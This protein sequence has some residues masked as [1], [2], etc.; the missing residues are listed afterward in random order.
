MKSIDP[1]SFGKLNS[2]VGINESKLIIYGYVERTINISGIVVDVKWY[3]VPDRTMKCDIL[4]GREFIRK[5]KLRFE[6]F[7]RNINICPVEKMMSV[8]NPA[9]DAKV[10]DVNGNLDR[11]SDD[12][13]EIMNIEYES[14]FSELKVNPDVSDVSKLNLINVYETNYI[15]SQKGNNA[16]SFPEDFKMKIR[17]KEDKIFHYNPRRLS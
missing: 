13:L 5:S 3:V 17:L 10:D 11:Y 8:V 1:K 9:I 6:L 4:F 16:H 14:D 12:V 2:L 7:G 15:R